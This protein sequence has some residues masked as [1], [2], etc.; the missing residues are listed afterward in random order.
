MPWGTHLSDIKIG[1]IIA[2]KKENCSSRVIA[3]K[4][5]QSKTV[6]NNFLSDPKK[7]GKQ[8]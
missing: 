7:Y 1:Q 6:V 5:G 2:F 8:I 4:I 3:Q